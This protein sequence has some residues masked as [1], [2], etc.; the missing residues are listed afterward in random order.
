M[1][2]MDNF[3]TD[4]PVTVKQPDYYAMVKQVAKAELIENAVNANVPNAYIKAM[5]TG[6]APTEG[7]FLESHI[8]T[9]EYCKEVETDP[10]TWSCRTCHW[11]NWGNNDAED[12]KCV[13]CEDGSYYKPIESEGKRP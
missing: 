3:T 10:D 11:R 12:V 6:E 9:D 13:G 7:D 1:G 4:S 2:F 8:A 5:L